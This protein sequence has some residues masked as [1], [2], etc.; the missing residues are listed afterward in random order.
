MILQLPLLLLRWA[1]SGPI[2][3][4]AAVSS[5]LWLYRLIPNVCR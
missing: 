2:R 4:F 5:H 3:R 1:R